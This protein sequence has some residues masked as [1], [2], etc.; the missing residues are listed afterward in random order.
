MRPVYRCGR[1]ALV[2]CRMLSAAVQHSALVFVAIESCIFSFGHRRAHHG[3]FTAVFCSFRSICAVFV[4]N[5]LV[6]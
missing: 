6:G 2:G 1:H 3:S 5:R 4:G